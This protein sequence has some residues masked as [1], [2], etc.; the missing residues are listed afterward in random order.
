MSQEIL[1]T[2]IIGPMIL[3]F[4][5]SFALYSKAWKK[6]VKNWEKNHSAIL[7]MMIFNLIFGLTIINLHNVW[8][9]SPYLIVTIIGWGA[10]LKAIMYFLLPEDQ[11]KKLIKIFNKQFIYQIAGPIWIVLGGWLSYIAY[12]K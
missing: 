8:K 4:G 3:V 2:A 10:F 11:M 12:L 1:L 7:S 9:W 5:L 6:I